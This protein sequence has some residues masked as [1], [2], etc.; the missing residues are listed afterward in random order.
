MSDPSK[1]QRVS[2]KKRS[3]KKRQANRKEW[4]AYLLVLIAAGAFGFLIVVGLGV[5]IVFKQVIRAPE[6]SEML[7]I[8]AGESIE[9]Q[10]RDDLRPSPLTDVV[11]VEFPEIP[12]D[13]DY[14]ILPPPAAKTKSREIPGMMIVGDEPGMFAELH[15][16]M[17]SV[18]PGDVIE[19]RTN[20]ILYLQPC[21]L[22]PKYDKETAEGP[23]TPFEIPVTIRAGQGFTPLIRNT[24]TR[25]NRVVDLVGST[26]ILDGLQFQASHILGKH[27]SHVHWFA[28]EGNRM[29]VQNCLF[30][31]G[32]VFVTVQNV[33]RDEF[34]DENDPRR[35]STICLDRCFLV[36][37]HA[38]TSF[39]SMTD[40]AI[41]RTGAICTSGK[42]LQF[43]RPNN[44]VVIVHSTFLHAEG[45]LLAG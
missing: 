30:Q 36:A 41:A 1:R 27:P 12:D 24:T 21:H 5:Q 18:I 33:A 42:V 20:R 34:P 35:S 31:L 38:C 11:D 3:T 25:W 16:A 9:T 28:G 22:G 43:G 39:A 44:R 15:D 10:P 19:I 17:E 26:L 37:A 7:E 45:V 2:A 23:F 40:V 8:D 14:E 32:S 4:P 29:L 6:R 13:A